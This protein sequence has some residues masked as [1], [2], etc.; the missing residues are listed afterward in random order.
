MGENPRGA[1]ARARSVGSA[2]NMPSYR[3]LPE[4]YAGPVAD[5]VR[6]ASACE[7]AG[8]L[9]AAIALHEQAIAQSLVDR[10]ALPGFVCGRLAELLRRVKRYD[11]EVAL[12]ERYRA[13][14]SDDIARIRF[15]ARLSKARILAERDRHDDCGALASVRN[16]R[17][18]SARR[19]AATGERPVC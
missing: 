2:L 7:K 1:S 5:L 16:I 8:D 14:Q 3:A 4:H 18:S 10:P 13:S 9:A 15:D 11:D 12:L 6:L 17:R 19:R